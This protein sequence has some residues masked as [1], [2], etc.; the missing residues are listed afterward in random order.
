MRKYIY[1]I[2][3]GE[4]LSNIDPHFSGSEDSLSDKGLEQAISVAKKFKHI[5]VENIYHSGI[6]RAKKTAE[7]IEKVTGVNPKVKEFF[8]ERRGNFSPDTVFEHVEDFENLKVRLI[9]TK[10]FLEGLSSKHTVIVSHAIFLKALTAYL[11]FEDSLTEDLL[12]KFDDA[13]VVDNTGVLKFM[14][15]EEK[16]KWRIMSWN[17]LNHLPR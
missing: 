4:C 2:R 8:K 16:K 6:L 11:V 15:N 1:F 7:E 12:R 9:E 10:N 5:S 3:H 13:L 17:D 14:F